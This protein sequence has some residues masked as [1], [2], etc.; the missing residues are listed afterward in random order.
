VTCEQDG[1]LSV[2]ARNGTGGEITTTLTAK[3]NGVDVDVTTH[4]VDL[5]GALVN[6]S[7]PQPQQPWGWGSQNY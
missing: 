7:T 1:A 6:R 3:G 2:T 4:D 5:G